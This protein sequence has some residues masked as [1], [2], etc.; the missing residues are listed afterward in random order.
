MN[1][2][3]ET[4]L[5]DFIDYLE[6]TEESQWCVDIVRSKDQEKNCLFGHLFN[7]AGDDKTGS[8]YWDYF[9]NA[10]AT[11]CMVYP[12]NDGNNQRYQQPTPKQRCIA[13]LKAIQSGEEE[14]TYECMERCLVEHNKKYGHTT[15]V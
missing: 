10:Y 1:E 9:E 2:V 7:F 12:V 4:F 13:Y 3:P 5:Q 11:T 15:N 8:F 14:T 6:R